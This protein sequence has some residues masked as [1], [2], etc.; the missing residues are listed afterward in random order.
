MIVDCHT[1]LFDP[2]VMRPG[3]AVVVQADASRHV[4]SLSPVDRALVHGFKSVYLDTEIPNRTIADYVRQYSSKLIGVAGI[5]PLAADCLDELAIADEELSL[6]GVTVSPALQ[7]F[8]PCA[9]DAMRVYAACAERRMPIFFEHNH[10]NPAA[11]LDFARP[12]LLDEVAREFPQL[13]IVVTRL[14]SPWL[15]ETVLLLG[16][17]PNV[18]ADV[19]GLLRQPWTAYNALM[20]AH[21]HGVMHKLLFGS[22]FPYRSSAECIEAL[23]SINQITLGTNM[24]AIPRAELRG[25]VERDAL[26]LLGIAD[27]RRPSAIMEDDDA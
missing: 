2:G 23:Y 20:V 5:D 18:Y 19:S 14:G 25:I 26:A 22:D 17:H 27:R 4:Q 3:E 6:Q 8:H 13:R 1:Q 10:R 7:N 24:P 21:E 9:T 15:G 11:K 12:H 16:K